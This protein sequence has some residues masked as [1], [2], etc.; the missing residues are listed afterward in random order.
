MPLD[1]NASARRDGPTTYQPDNDYWTDER[2][3]NM[4]EVV[5]T[6][7]GGHGDEFKVKTAIAWKA[8]FAAKILN[9]NYMTRFISAL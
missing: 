1:G 4:F 2:I 7:P 6:P 9:Q 5:I 8:F 3:N